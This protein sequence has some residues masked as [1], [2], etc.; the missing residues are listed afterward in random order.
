M[1]VPLSLEFNGFY[2]DIL[3]KD[4]TVHSLQWNENSNHTTKH[5]PKSLMLACAILITSTNNH[6]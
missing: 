3:N 5:R 1:G 6:V 2:P 4:N